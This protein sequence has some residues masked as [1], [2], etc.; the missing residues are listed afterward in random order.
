MTTIDLYRK[1]KAGEISCEK[2]LYEVRRDNNL[3]F[4][5]NLTSYDDA[6]KILKNKGIVT[7]VDTK[8]AKADE[9][10]KAEVKPKATTVKKP[11]SLHIDVAHP[12]EYRLGLQHELECLG[13]YTD[14][15]F[16]K[17]KV[18]VLKNLAKDVNFYT[19]LKNA[20]ASSYTFK[21]PE[22]QDD[23]FEKKID[24]GGRMEIK[25]YK[26]EKANVKDNLGKK[27][28]GKV[29]PKGVKVMPDK[30]VTG[31]TKTIKEGFEVKQNQD[32]IE[33]SD[34]SG[35]Y[36]SD[37]QNGKVSFS[38]FFPDA[39]QLQDE[40]GPEG[41]TKDNWKDVLG[42][43][44]AFV[45]IIDTIGGDVEA[46]DDYIEITVDADKLKTIKEGIEEAED[47]LSPK[48]E[49][50]FNMIVSALK[51]A[52]TEDEFSR[53]H[54]TILFL[55]K[56][57]SSMIFKKL[58]KMGLVTIKN[59]EIFYNNGP[60]DTVEEGLKGKF[61]SDDNTYTYDHLINTDSP[62]KEQL[63]KVIDSI[64]KDKEELAKKGKKVKLVKGDTVPYLELT[65]DT[66]EE[67]SFMGGVDL[68]ASFDKFKQDIIGNKEDFELSD[69]NAFED[70]MKKYDFYAEMSDDPRKYDAQQAMDMQ[71]KQLAK[72]IGVE[73][74]V[75]LFNQ[76]APADRKIDASFFGMNENKI[77][78]IKEALKK[79]LKEEDPQ[80][81]PISSNIEKKEAELANLYTQKANIL[82]KPGTQS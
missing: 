60:E 42:P 50:K 2:F 40:F 53:V 19:N 69:E 16:E 51:K 5:T 29:K 1:H 48:M 55:P 75:K 62:N 39:E 82:K 66:V 28:A 81:K 77:S 41:I 63:K 47:F 38:V 33:I 52:K 79:A 78:K 36:V 74:A 21:T 35:D 20:Q 46:M 49:K 18:K 56:A 34:D 68:G 61:D 23:K 22:S 24:S 13:D 14:E 7:E 15:A 6:V 65:E 26:N 64:K 80:L 30:G 27:E 70:L 67:G 44:H 17:S 25:G 54:Y 45:K 43:N 12:Y 31:S 10:V 8:E 32:E 37:I 9:A 4:I 3:P 59:D 11:K 71:L 76:K 58:E 57:V 72:K 73:K